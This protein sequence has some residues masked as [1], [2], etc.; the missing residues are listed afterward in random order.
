MIFLLLFEL[1]ESFLDKNLKLQEEVK[2]SANIF[3]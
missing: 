1:P 2:E 3:T